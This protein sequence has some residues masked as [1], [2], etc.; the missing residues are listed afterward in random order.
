MNRGWGM[1]SRVRILASVLLCALSTMDCQ[2]SD[3]LIDASSP[4]PDIDI[5]Y[6][7]SPGQDE[8]CY[9]DLK[10]A[11]PSECVAE[12][13]CALPEMNADFGTVD[14][15]VSSALAVRVI[16][17]GGALLNVDAPRAGAGSSTSF[18]LNPAA[19]QN[20]TYLEVATGTEATFELTF[21]GSICGTQSARIILTSN[22]AE[23]PEGG[24]GTQLTPDSPLYFNIKAH[25]GGPCLCP[26]E[27]TTVD[28]GQSVVGDTVEK[29]W[30]FENCGDADLA[31]SDTTIGQD[32][33]SVFQVVGTDYEDDGILAPGER[34]AVDLAFIP[35]RV[36]APPHAGELWI[37]TNSTSAQPFKVLLLGEGLERPSC[38]LGVFPTSINFGRTSTASQ[39]EVRIFNEGS[40]ACRIFRAERSAGSSEFELQGTLPN[41]NSPIIL[42][43]NDSI[44]ATLAYLASTGGTASATFEFEADDSYGAVSTATFDATVNPDIDSEGCVLDVQPTYGDFGELS[45]GEIESENFAFGNLSSGSGLPIPIPGQQ[46]SSCTISSAEIV[47]GAPDFRLGDVGGA[48]TDFLG[49]PPGGFLDANV[50]VFFEPQTEG[51]KTGILRIV[52]N[53]S[54]GN[55]TFDI[56]LYGN[57]LG[58]KLCVSVD[59]DTPATLQCGASQPC[60]LADFGAVSPNSTEDRDITLTNC[61]AGTMKIRGIEMDPASAPQFIK[62]APIPSLM[63][64][65]L[66]PGASTT[67]TVRYAPENTDGDFGSFMVIS[68]ASNGTSARVDLRGHYDGTCEAI[69]RCSPELSA[70]GTVEV[71]TQ[72]LRTVTCTNFGTETIN[73]TNINSLG[74]PEI[75]VV[76]PTLQTLAPGES[77]TVQMTCTP[78]EGVSIDG[79]FQILS[80]ACDRTPYTLDASCDGYE[81]ELPQCIGSDTYEPVVKWEWTGTPTY[82]DY[83]DVWVT[84][85]VINL[86]DDNGDGLVDVL[87]TPDVIFTALKSTINLAGG[88]GNNNGQGGTDAFCDS[89]NAEPAVV[90]AVSGDNGSTLWE[91]GVLPSG[92]PADPSARVMESEGQLSAGDIDGD[93]L[94]EIIGL[95]YTFIPPPDDCDATDLDCCIRGKFAYGSLYALEHDGTFKWESDPWKLPEQ[96]IENAGAPALGDM[97]G[98]GFPEI[99][100]GNAV[101][102]NLGRLIFEGITATNNERG[103]GEG[104]AGHGPMSVFTDL[105]GDGKNEL[106]AGRTA[107]DALGRVLWDRYDFGDG[108]TTVAN[109]DSDQLPEIILF[110]GNNQL[111]VLESDGTTKYGPIDVPSGSFDE[112]T[113]EEEG[114]IAT[115]PAVGDLDGDGFP[116]I[117]IAATNL[118][119]VYEHDLTFKWS[120]S[121]N[122]QTG[123]SGPTTF[124]F[125]GD[126]RAEVVYADEGNVYIWD[127]VSSAEKYRA[128]RGSRT[129][130]DNPVVAD[131]DNDGHADILLSM[132][133]PVPG[134][135]HGVIAYSNRKNNWVAT[136]RVWNQHAYHI[137]NISESG[138]VPAIEIPDWQTENVYRSNTV[139]C[140]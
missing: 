89:N 138:I 110:N 130:V 109:V 17:R 90:I 31:I 40:L 3:N 37:D 12:G 81:P 119:H 93:G 137:T 107:F 80:N 19:A 25:V 85:T 50:T 23:I 122:D 49:I 74:A 62:R 114:Y 43:P 11:R 2:C 4:V 83:D 38:Q 26:L 33:D 41:E 24:I 57:A 118:V 96:Y 9:S 52:S 134:G 77:M 115:N 55:A 132:E 106:V 5:C 8:V 95:K 128:D 127:G 139:R 123:A 45:V 30:P 63:P 51:V 59:G 69:L 97:N 36:G 67:V 14:L 28:F 126:G 86:T 15:G 108:L 1:F 116:E 79:R 99:A 65:T 42:Q 75:E 72:G 105:D 121:A 136:R 82:P 48:F 64:I 39:R 20:E 133:S 70:F 98:D 101:Y 13:D 35:T 94:P 54:V 58:P 6:V 111:I 53:D 125:E 104:G 10:A 46:N 32:P 22:D 71:G 29:R 78:T 100:F 44:T 7:P 56:P 34:G 87:D 129:I 131:V 102:D 47:S 61:G 76:T 103:H 135:R 60:A 16:N 112:E 88:G 124:D 140:E 18:R 73:V 27:G 66:T 91:W 92:D 21:R 68:N 120:Q 84:P 117:V 113:G